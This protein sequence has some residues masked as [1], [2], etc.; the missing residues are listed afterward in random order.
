VVADDFGY[1]AGGQE[2]RCWIVRD[3]VAEAAA[4]AGP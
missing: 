1:D 4:P 3:L 2:V